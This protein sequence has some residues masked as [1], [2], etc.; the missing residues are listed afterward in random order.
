MP[1][2]YNSVFHE[3]IEIHMELRKEELGNE[4]YRH[5]KRTVKLFD[6]YLYQIGL[7]KKE[8]SEFIVEEWIKEVSK[9][10]SINTVSQHVHYIRQLLLYLANCGYRCFIPK[11]VITRDTYIL[12][13]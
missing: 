2:A 13:L 11:T 8:I 10:I 4:A 12:S 6:D 3:E 9:G 1:K 7:K 5:Y